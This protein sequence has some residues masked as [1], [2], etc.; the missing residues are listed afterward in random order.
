MGKISKGILGGFSGKVG[1]VI[2]SSWNSISYMRSLAESYNDPKT[3]K[4]VCQRGRF[5]ET[6][7]FLKTIAPYLRVGYEKPTAGQSAYSSAMSY[8]LRNAVNGCGDEATVEFPKALVSRG[9]LTMVTDATVE[10]AGGKLSFTWTDNSGNGNAQAD[11][12]AMVLA[13]NKVKAEAVYNLEAATRAD[14]A[15]E[16]T[17]PSGWGDDALAVYLSFRSTAGRLSSNSL[18]LQ[19]GETTSVPGGGSG[20]GGDDESGQGTFG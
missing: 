10:A 14:G 6:V 13:F 1:T 5:A 19:D 18:C 4:Q 7:R 16:L 12:A 15:A 20:E 8:V 2:G 17:L 3:E 11:D 9:S